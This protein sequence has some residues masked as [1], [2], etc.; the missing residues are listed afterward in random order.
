ELISAIIDGIAEI[1]RGGIAGAAKLIEDA[2]AKAL[3]IVIGFLASLLGI[4]D[5]S[6]KGQGLIEKIRGKID[7]AI[8]WV[9]MKA[10]AAAGKVMGAL[11]FGKKEE[12]ETAA[13]GDPKH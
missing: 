10:K 9:I 6:K 12:K 8:D 5:L 3:P 13:S 4:G 2:L 1:A 7:K 11:G